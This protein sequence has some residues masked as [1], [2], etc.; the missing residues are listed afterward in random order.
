[1]SLLTFWANRDSS[2]RIT[3]C[4]S[5]GNTIALQPNDYMR[6]KIGH[7]QNDPIIDLKAGVANANG[8]SFA[9]TNPFDLFL[10]RADLALLNRG[11][12]NLEVSLY[13]DS[14]GHFY[15]AQDF[16]LEIRG[17]MGGNIT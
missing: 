9:N 17:A 4:D 7:E 6:V 3:V 10:V 11:I 5:D 8:S 14:S 16:Q 13:D 1:M 12:W 15:F 2:V